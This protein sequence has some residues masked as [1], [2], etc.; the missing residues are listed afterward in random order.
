MKIKLTIEDTE[1]YAREGTYVMFRPLR[2]ELVR[3]VLYD[4]EEYVLRSLSEL[5][6][7]K[8]RTDS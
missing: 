2:D 4:I 3:N 6:A 5:N 7:L 8:V 1:P